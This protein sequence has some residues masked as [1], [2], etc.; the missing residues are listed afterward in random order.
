MISNANQLLCFLI[1]AVILLIL[2]Q[3]LAGLPAKDKQTFVIFNQACC[4]FLCILQQ[5]IKMLCL[6]YNTIYLKIFI[7]NLKPNPSCCSYLNNCL[8]LHILS[9][10]TV[11]EKLRKKINSNRLGHSF[12]SVE[13]DIQVLTFIYQFLRFVNKEICLYPY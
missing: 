13:T 7:K 4:T 9:G 1:F 8:H 2:L 3:S 5:C 12:T 10:T 11:F 6:Y